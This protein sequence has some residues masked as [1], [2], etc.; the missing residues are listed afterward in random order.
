LPLFLSKQ[1]VLVV[2]IIIDKNADPKDSIFNTRSVD[3]DT[4]P[5]STP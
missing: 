2:L 1:H 4:A 3:Y 5:S